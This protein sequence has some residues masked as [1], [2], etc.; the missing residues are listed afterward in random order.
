MPV[1]RELATGRSCSSPPKVSSKMVTTLFHELRAGM[2]V[3]EHN[4]G[5]NIVKCCRHA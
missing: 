5:G 4:F 1:Q 2:M 3:A